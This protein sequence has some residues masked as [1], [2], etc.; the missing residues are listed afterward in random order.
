MAKVADGTCVAPTA[1]TIGNG[2]YP[3]SRS[4]YV[5]VNTAKAAANPAVVGY[6]D[7]YLSAGVIDDVLKTVPYV[8]LPAAELDATRQAWE[9]AKAAS[10]LPSSPRAAGISATRPPCPSR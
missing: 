4:L 1:E 5:Y 6:V 2:T 7:Y 3:L 9:T 8:A 10:N